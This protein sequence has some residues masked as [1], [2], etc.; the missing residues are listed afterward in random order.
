[1]ENLPGTSLMLEISTNWILAPIRSQC[2]LSLPPWKHQIFWCFQGEE[3]WC[4]GNEWVN[5]IN[6]YCTHFIKLAGWQLPGV[7]IGWMKIFPGGNLLCGNYPAGNFP[8][9]NFL[10]GSFPGWELSRWGFSGWEFSW[11]GVVRVGIFRVEVFLG[12]WFESAYCISVTKK[13][14]K[15]LLYQ[16]RKHWIHLF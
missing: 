6:N 3:K 15:Q 12:G 7:V 10:G 1:M 5:Y 14:I 9:D 16:N 13:K 8:G 11:V 4:I 2:T